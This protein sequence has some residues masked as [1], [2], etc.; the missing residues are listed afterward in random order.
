M[1]F[2]LNL[3]ELLQLAVDREKVALGDRRLRVLF[4][5][6]RVEKGNVYAVPSIAVPCR[7]A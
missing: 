7:I 4:C 6:F 5:N 1:R 2:L 3:V